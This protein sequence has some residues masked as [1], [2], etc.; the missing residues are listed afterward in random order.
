MIHQHHPHIIILSSIHHHYNGYHILSR[1]LSQFMECMVLCKTSALEGQVASG[2]AAQFGQGVAKA[3][4]VIEIKG[5]GGAMHSI[6]EEER[7]AFAAH[8]RID[9]YSVLSVYSLRL[10]PY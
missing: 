8:V 7:E 1:P 5:A 6:S 9:H 4:H 2:A 10:S 3:A